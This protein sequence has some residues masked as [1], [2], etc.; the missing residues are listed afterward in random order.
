M[1]L[2]RQQ[3]LDLLKTYN[4]EPFHLRHALT[5][6]AIMRWFAQELG[7]GDQADFWATVGLLHDLDF[8]QWPDEH[9]VKVRELME[10]Q[11]LDAALIHAVVSHGWGMTGADVQPE[12]QME[13]VLFAVDELTGLI[14]AAALMRPSKSVQ[15]MELSSLKKKFKDKKFAAGCSRDTIAQG[16][17]LLGWELNDLLDRTLQAMKACEADIEREVSAL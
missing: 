8:E 11:G 4:K 13:K 1:E 6:E 15:D 5:V 7:Y 17:Q 10:A 16:A 3:A 2:N 9:C 14:G 12:H